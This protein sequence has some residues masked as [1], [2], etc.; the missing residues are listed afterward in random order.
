MAFRRWTT[1]LK[2]VSYPIWLFHS[3]RLFLRKTLHGLGV[4]FKYP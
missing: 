2:S 1:H 4:L 3:L